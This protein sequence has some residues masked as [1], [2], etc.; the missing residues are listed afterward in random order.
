MADGLQES[1]NPF[2]SSTSHFLNMLAEIVENDNKKTDDE[3][4]S[5]APIA[6]WTQLFAKYFLHVNH[7]HHDDMLFYV[8]KDPMLH[9]ERAEVKVFRRESTKNP[10]LGDPSFDWTE[11]LYLNLILQ[12]LQYKLTCAIC[13]RRS[14][15]DVTIHKKVSQV[16]YASPSRHDMDAK[17]PAAE[18]S[19]PNIF[20]PIDSFDEIW[21][22]LHLRE[23]EMV[24]VEII[25]HDKNMEFISVIFLGSVNY[26][27]L[28]KVYQKKTEGLGT[29]TKWASMISM[30]L[31]KPP[32]ETQFVKMKGPS[33]KGYAEMAVELYKDSNKN[34][35]KGQDTTVQNSSLVSSRSEPES[36]YNHT[37]L[38][39]KLPNYLTAV[40]RDD[41]GEST[42]MPASPLEGRMPTSLKTQLTY[43]TLPWHKII[44]DILKAYENPTDTKKPVLGT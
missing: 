1:E 31:Y 36:L 34:D 11:T 24:C 20:F 7:P 3:C 30:G 26:D 16:V 43:V 10:G 32:S 22:D 27:A 9:Q 2:A 19:Y 25:A 6:F 37:V 5:V 38:H 44:L 13:S 28:M 33:G 39:K 23:G 40:H 41:S 29:A 12:Q 42:S 18:L 15:E 17:G 14:P 4:V 8:Q 35:K 21:T